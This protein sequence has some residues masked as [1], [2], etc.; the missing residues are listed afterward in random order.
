MADVLT[1]EQVAAEAQM[2]MTEDEIRHRH[3]SLQKQI[4]RLT[5]ALRKAGARLHT[6]QRDGLIMQPAAVVDARQIIS[7]ALAEVEGEE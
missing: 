5:D 7:R 3:K 2:M 1:P 4:S 6:L